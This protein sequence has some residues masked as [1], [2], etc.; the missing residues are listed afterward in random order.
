MRSEYRVGPVFRSALVASGGMC[1]GLGIAA[2]AALALHRVEYTQLSPA[3]VPTSPAAALGFAACGLGLVGI[4]AWF[5]RV[6]SVLAMVTVSMVVSLAAERVVGAGPRVES[7]FAANFG[8]KDWIALAPNTALV[9]LLGAMALLL[10]HTQR[11]FERRL[12]AIA[13]MGSI[14]FAIGAVSC[15]GYMTGVPSYAWQPQAPMSF[16][17]SIC[18]CVLGMGILMSACR[19]SELDEVGLPRWLAP[20]VCVGGLAINI[21]TAVAYSCGEPRAWR[22]ASVAGLLPMIIVSTGVSAVAARWVRRSTAV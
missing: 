14:V 11:W 12:G 10:R 3:S 18:A 4:G 9:L 5:P 6:T 7:L 1:A 13:I 22:P 20:A 21:A 19:Y 16:L 15:V 8:A 17:S 2:L